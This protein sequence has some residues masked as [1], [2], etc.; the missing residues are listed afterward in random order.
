MK[1]YS[2]SEVIAV[3]HPFLRTL[4]WLM[5]LLIYGALGLGVWASELPRGAARGDVLFVHK[6]LGVAALA[7]IVVRV[8]ARLAL[9]SPPYAVALGRLKHV[10]AQAAHLLLYALMI[11][12]P[13][14]GYLTSSAGGH[15]V[16]FFG[17]VTL[18]NIVGDNKAL[19]ESASQAHLVFAWAMGV[20][21]AL[22]LAA[23][24]WHARI[25]RD[26]VFT[27]MSPRFQPYAKAR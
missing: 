22:H 11:A 4:H 8:V 25:R 23:V 17:L 12:L 7:L 20:L 21:L 14:S 10:S 26:A 1:S 24:A 19:D 13:V 6:S 3:Y 9:G 15:D 5:A 18:P 16:S 2:P 27:R